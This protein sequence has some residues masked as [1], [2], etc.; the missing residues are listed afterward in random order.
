MNFKNNVTF[1]K[2]NHFLAMERTDAFTEIVF[3]P[4]V[5]LPLEFVFK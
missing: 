3:N 5:V 1:V 2:E 4:N